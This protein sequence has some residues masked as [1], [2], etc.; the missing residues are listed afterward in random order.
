MGMMF[1]VSSINTV[2]AQSNLPF[3][4]VGAKWWYTLP[5]YMTF[6]QLPVS[7]TI[8]ESIGDTIIQGINASQLIFTYDP[9]DYQ[10]CYGLNSTFY[11][12]AD[13]NKVY[14][15]NTHSEVFNLLYDFNANA[16]DSWY[17]KLSCDS[18][19]FPWS[20][21]DSMLVTVDSVSFKTVNGQQLKILHTNSLGSVI[22]QIGMVEGPFPLVFYCTGLISEDCAS[23]LRCYEDTIIGFYQ[24]PDSIACD[25]IYT[26]GINELSHDFKFSISPNPSSGSFNLI[27]FLPKNQD[28]LLQIVDITGKMIFEMRLP[29]W[30]TLQNIYLP[31]LAQGIYALKITSGGSSVVKKIVLRE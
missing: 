20:Q 13:S 21:S 24:S 9:P 16:G 26:V 11:M 23:T 3:A 25:S 22:E 12:Y 14:L 6:P 30:S 17:L 19:F 2:H 4:P 1:L 15:Y 28:G 8:I 29:Q 18:A 7:Y 5:N 31:N 10:Y 27:Y